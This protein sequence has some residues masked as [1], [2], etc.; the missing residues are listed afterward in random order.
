MRLQAG[1]NNFKSYP[2]YTFQDAGSGFEPYVATLFDGT[3]NAEGSF[4]I[5]VSQIQTEN[6]PGL[7]NATFTTRIF[8]EGG[9]FSISSYTTQYSPY[10][11]Y[12][13]IRLPEPDDDWYSTREPV[14][15]SG[16]IVNPLGKKTNTQTTV[17]IRVY[18]T[19]WR[20]WWDAGE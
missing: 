16:V 3:T 18:E 9:D 12:T 20:W 6:A 19:T 5:D 1:N 10:T 15:L 2:D 11:L 13:G 8:E 4:K 14:K 7:L 17:N